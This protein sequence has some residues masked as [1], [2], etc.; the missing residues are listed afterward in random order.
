[1]ILPDSGKWH[2]VNPPGLVLAE[3]YTRGMLYGCAGSCS[4]LT[5]EFDLEEFDSCQEVTKNII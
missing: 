1:M 2:N 5:S 3:L 4:L